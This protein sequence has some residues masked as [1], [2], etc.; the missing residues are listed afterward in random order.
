MTTG[1]LLILPTASHAPKS[2]TQGTDDRTSVTSREDMLQLLAQVKHPPKLDMPPENTLVGTKIA[3]AKSEE[4]LW[5]LPP[6]VH[7][8]PDTTVVTPKILDMDV[9]QRMRAAHKVLRRARKRTKFPVAQAEAFDY[10]GNDMM[11]EGGQTEDSGVVLSM[12]MDASVNGSHSL[13]TSTAE[14]VAS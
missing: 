2:T 6:I 8:D 13:A 4:S 7:T 3:A 5:H 10:N 12:D 11:S 1:I 14:L 9:N